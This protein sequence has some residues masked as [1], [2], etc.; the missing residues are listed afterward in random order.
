MT[1][2]PGL[3]VL[4][5]LNKLIWQLNC[6]FT[7]T[8]QVDKL[9]EIKFTLPQLFLGTCCRYGQINMCNQIVTSEIRN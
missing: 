3:F 9:N 5:G 8:D 1:F 7:V 4:K 6:L 2:A